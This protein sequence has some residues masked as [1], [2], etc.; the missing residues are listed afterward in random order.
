MAFPIHYDAEKLAL[1]D[2]P[3]FVSATDG[4]TPTIKIPIRMLGM[5][6]P[7]LHFRGATEETPGKFD[8]PFATFLAKAGRSLDPGLKAYLK[9]RLT[10]G[11][12]TRHITAGIAAS[13][14]FNKIVADRLK[15]ISES[16][17]KVLTPRHFFVM[18][19]KEE[20]F[21]RNGRLLAYI[22][23]SYT[24]QERKDIPISKRPTFN[25][26]MVRDGHATSLVIYP[27][28]PKPFDLALMRKA[29]IAARSAKR[30]LWK[31]RTPTLHAFEF[32]WIVETMAGRRDGPDRFCGDIT[33][34][35]LYSPQLYYKVPPENRL[36]FYPKHVGR[37][38]EM[39]FTLV[40]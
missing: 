20:I 12:S 40:P 8:R 25:L 34:A 19:S 21:D 29:S 35:E 36:W 6:A 39:G 23:A 3:R 14:H 37:A 10:G 13:A 26:Q 11:A 18:V 33:T 28:V 15:R 32:R 31:S 27:N 5:D 7:E 16:T 2:E 22:N 4:D 24:K 17:G 9:N 38:F 30:G 1:G